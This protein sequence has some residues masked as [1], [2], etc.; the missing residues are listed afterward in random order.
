MLGVLYTLA[1]S[2]ISF[3]EMAAPGLSPAHEDGV[4]PGLEGLEDVEDVDAAGAQ[5]LDDAHAGRVLHPGGAGHIRGGVGAVG[6]DKR[7][8]FGIEIHWKFLSNSFLDFS[9]Q[10]SAVSGQDVRR[11]VRTLQSCQLSAVSFQLFNKRGKHLFYFHGLAMQLLIRGFF[12][13][14]Q[15]PCEK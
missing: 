11:A 14:S 13:K 10:L 3:Q 2:E 1:G 12:Q 6:A 4:G 15:V 5:V 9:F 7:Q 8:D